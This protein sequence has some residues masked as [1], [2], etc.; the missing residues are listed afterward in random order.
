MNLKNRTCII[1]GSSS[2]LGESIAKKLAELKADIWL[3]ARNEENLERVANDIRNSRGK[4]NFVTCDVSSTEDIDKAILKIQEQTKSIDILI[5]NSG[6]WLQ[7]STVSSSREDIKNVF[8]VNTLGTIFM[9]QAVLPMMEAVDE[10][11]IFNVV[12][13][14]GVEASGEWPIYTASKYAIR[15][16]TDSLK[17]ELASTNIKVSGFYPEGI[18]T[19]LFTNAGLGLE[20]QPWMMDKDEVADII[21]YILQ[22]PKDITIS[23]IE[24]RK[25][26]GS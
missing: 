17:A 10:A 12:S 15:G 1:T 7:G 11:H 14:A 6:K 25:K 23:H 9:T 13:A 18:N 3:L 2:G 22:Q 20:N 4:A 21:C 16:F 19:S 8:D 24:V 26:M 5:N